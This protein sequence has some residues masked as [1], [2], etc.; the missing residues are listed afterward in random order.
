VAN[1]LGQAIIIGTA[2]LLVRA[3]LLA[4]AC[5]LRRPERS[6][7]DHSSPCRSR[8]LRP[9]GRRGSAQRPPAPCLR[10]S[11]AWAHT[12]TGGPGPLGK[13]T[14]NR[15][16]DAERGNGERSESGHLAL[17]NFFLPPVD[18]DLRLRDLRLARFVFLHRDQPPVPV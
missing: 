9:L 17:P 15:F 18:R 6:P 4:R 5:S 7:L 11:A 10:H 2:G 16:P 3:G 8:W 13:V 14:A 1:R 12:G